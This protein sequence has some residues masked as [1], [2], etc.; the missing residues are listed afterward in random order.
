MEINFQ[1]STEFESQGKR[2]RA[3][4]E[5]AFSLIDGRRVFREFQV[6]FPEVE[7]DE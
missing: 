2:L 1:E 6:A 5:N 7:E 4:I 3:Q